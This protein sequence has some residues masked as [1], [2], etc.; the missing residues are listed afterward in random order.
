[1]LLIRC[2]WCGE[3]SQIEFAYGGDATVKR[4]AEPARASDGEWHDYVYVRA[5]PKGP[6]DELWQHAA[7]C[8][9]FFKVRRDTVS[10]EIVATAPPDGWLGGKSG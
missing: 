10:H 1:M 9:R 3:R 4:P 5:N 2:P 7:G 8:R 6:H